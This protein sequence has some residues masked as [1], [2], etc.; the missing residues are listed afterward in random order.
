MAKLG[1]LLSEVLTLQPESFANS[2]DF[3]SKFQ[4]LQVGSKLETIV[5]EIQGVHQI[6]NSSSKMMK[7]CVSGILDYSRINGGKF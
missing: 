2:K 1:S 5:G 3:V 6:L 4:K 7:N